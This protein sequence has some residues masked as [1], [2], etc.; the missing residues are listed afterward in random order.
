[1]KECLLNA[2]SIIDQHWQGLTQSAEIDIETTGVKNIQPDKDLDMKLPALD[3]FLSEM[4]NRR[5]NH[6]SSAFRPSSTFPSYPAARLPDNVEGPNNCKYFRLVALENWVDQHLQTW[7]S[8]NLNNTATCGQLRGLIEHYFANASAAYASSPI[9]MSIMYLTIAE[10]WIACDRSACTQYSLLGEYA[11]EL[12]IT[13]FQCLVLP[14]KHDMER[15]HNVERYLQSRR[16]AASASLPS[17]YRLFGHPSS[18]AVRFFDESRELQATLVEIECDAERKRA[19]KSQELKQLKTRYDNLMNQYNTGSCDTETYVYNRRHGYTATRHPNWCSRCSCKK[20]ADALS[21][22]IY[23]WP[24][25]S[26]SLV[27]KATVF[28]LKVPQAF[29]DW[30]DTSRYMISEVLRHLDPDAEKPS[31]S[32]TLNVHQDL[33]QMLSSLYFRRRIV[34]C[35]SVKPHSVTHRKKKKAIPHLTE[36]DVCL[37][38]ALQYAYFDTSLGAFTTDT[39]MCTEDIPMLCMY[40]V[41][42]RSKAL[43]R[44]MYHP[45]SAPDGTP[46]NEVIVSSLSSFSHFC[47]LVYAHVHFDTFRASPC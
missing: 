32:Y 27:A 20:Q 43:D 3:T 41:P 26:N 8:L 15:L 33:S 44:F 39:P 34:P 21:I 37:N 22:H 7:I 24:V 30:R 1:M 28:E 9:S 36:E 25:S 35:S 14:L 47:H 4:R 11:H 38:N 23:E 31:C 10:L 29:S 45:P 19:Q 40:H 12:H 6:S 5:H 18:F 16:E 2:H 46:A 13:E 17:I 42:Q